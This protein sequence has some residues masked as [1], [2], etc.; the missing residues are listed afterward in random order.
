MASGTEMRQKP[1]MENWLVSVREGFNSNPNP[2]KAI[3]WEEIKFNVIIF[4]IIGRVFV[5]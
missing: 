5:A 3:C 4:N 2:E 1:E